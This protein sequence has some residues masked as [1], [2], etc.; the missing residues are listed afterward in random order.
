MPT[1]AAARWTGCACHVPISHR[2]NA[3]HQPGV[4][5]ATG[6]RTRVGNPPA[7]EAGPAGG[8]PTATTGPAPCAGRSGPEWCPVGQAPPGLERR[9]PRA[10]SGPRSDLR[11]PPARAA[12]SSG[13]GPV[14]TVQARQPRLAKVGTLRQPAVTGDSKTSGIGNGTIPIS[15]ASAGSAS[16]VSSCQGREITRVRP[17]AGS[18]HW[19]RC[20]L[21]AVW[22]TG[23]ERPRPGSGSTNARCWSSGRPPRRAP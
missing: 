5:W 18:R 4:P 8:R 21:P 12:P 3:A 14:E 10:A 23:W 13:A 20:Q 6:A 2:T 17:G 15:G 7:S 19:S 16:A 9:P 1:V 22:M 11:A